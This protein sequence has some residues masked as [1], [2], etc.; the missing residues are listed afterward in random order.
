MKKQELIDNFLEKNKYMCSKFILFGTPVEIRSFQLKFLGDEKNSKKIKNI[1]KQILFQKIEPITEKYS[2]KL[3]VSYN[4]ILIRNQKT[5]WASCSSKKNLSF[6]IKMISLHESL[7]N[8]L[9]FHEML[10]LIE[11]NHSKKFISLIEKEFPNYK[12]MEDELTKYW[13]ILNNNHFWANF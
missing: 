6:N 13:F 3:G 1:L 2:K 11:K 8:Y 4:K 10:H 12:K 7:I 5:K 9:V